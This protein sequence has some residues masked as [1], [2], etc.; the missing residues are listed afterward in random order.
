MCQEASSQTDDRTSAF[1]TGRHQHGQLLQGRWVKVLMEV[2]T[3]QIGRGE[4]SERLLIRGNALH[5]EG[6]VKGQQLFNLSYTKHQPSL[7]QTGE[8]AIHLCSLHHNL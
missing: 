4:G 3:P 8:Y 7:K 1:R 5:C 6:H 2:V